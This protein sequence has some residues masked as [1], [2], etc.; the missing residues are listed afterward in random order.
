MTNNLPARWTP[1]KYHAEQVRLITSDARFKLVPAGRRSGKTERAKRYIIKTGYRSHK[2]CKWPDPRYFFAAPTRDQAKSIYWDDLKSMIPPEDIAGKPSETELKI[3]LM[4]GA[5]FKV[6]GMDKPDRIEGRPWDGGVLDEF[7]NM[8]QRVWSENVRPALADRAGWAWLIG[9]PEGRNHYYDLVKKAL[10]S[11]KK[12]WDVFSWKSSDILS[13]EEVESAR[14]DLDELTFSQEFEASFVTFAG[15]AYY[16]FNINVHV[17]KLKY[18]CYKPLILTFD[19]NISPGT[20]TIIQEQLLPTGLIGTGIIGE[21]HIPVNSTTP[22]VCSKIAQ[23][24]GDH[25]GVVRCYGDATGGSGGSAKV[26]GSDWD[27]INNSLRPIYRNRLEIRVLRSNPRERVRLNAVNSRL[28]TANGD[29]KLMIDPVAKNV[30][31]DFEGVRVLAGGVGSI[32]KK[33]DPKLSHLSDGIGY[34]ISQVHPITGSIVNA[35][36]KGMY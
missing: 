29:I 10:I 33:S 25:K 7:G 32:D 6:I 28:M 14:S 20:A 2:F 17:L 22:S 34:Y 4:N 15:R 36:V 19:F 5:T 13:A 1:L 11:D 16:K 21:V 23:D 3:R 9:V 26:M 8:R 18:D 35:K 31:K 30:I 12:E 27:L 24:W